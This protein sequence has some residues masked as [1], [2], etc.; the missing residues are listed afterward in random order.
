MSGNVTVHTLCPTGTKPVETI[1][2]ENPYNLLFTFFVAL[3]KKNYFCIFK[4]TMKV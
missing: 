2:K 3:I 1:R 4:R